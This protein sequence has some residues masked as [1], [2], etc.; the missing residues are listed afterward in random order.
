[1]KRLFKEKIKFLMR[2]VCRILVLPSY[3]LYLFLNLFFNEEKNFQ[4]FS[5]FYS[6]FP[7]LMGEYLR[8]E[9]YRLSLQRC[10]YDCCI[11]FGALLY[12]SKT[13]IGKGVYIGPY[14]VIGKATIGD[15]TLIGSNVEI[16][17][18][19]KQ[20]YFERTDIPIK[21]QGGE[22]PMIV[23]GED[24]WIGDGTIVMAHIGKKSVIGVHSLV[25]KEISEYSVAVGNP[26]KVIRKRT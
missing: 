15:F 8:R 13:V 2:G 14:C 22:F 3:L 4:G 23:I 1:M 26:A 17:N 12:S 18:G 6:L 16:L 11:S 10:S 25:H 21:E 19:S 9:F 7:G 24:C 20:H 5:Q